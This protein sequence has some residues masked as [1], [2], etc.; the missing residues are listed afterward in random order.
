[1]ENFFLNINITA[2]TFYLAIMLIIIGEGL[3]TLPFIKKWMVIWILTLL[4]V[5]I[6]FIFY[7]IRFNT[8]FEALIATSI[9]TFGYD[10]FVQVKKG[11]KARKS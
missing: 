11:I 10:A 1:M 7:G 8:L 3:K 6:N 4:S 2:Q 5:L 9:A